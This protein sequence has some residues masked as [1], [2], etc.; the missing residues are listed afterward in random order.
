LGIGKRWKKEEKRIE[1]GK[2]RRGLREERGK[3]KEGSRK[4]KVES[5]GRD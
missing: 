2:W 4:W 3:K 1:S 5:G